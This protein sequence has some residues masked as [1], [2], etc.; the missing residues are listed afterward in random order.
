MNETGLKEN[1]LHQ[2]LIRKPLFMGV[3]WRF[4]ILEMG[5]VGAIFFAGGLRF[6]S[7]APA[8]IAIFLIHFPLRR[9]IAADPMMIELVQRCLWHHTYYAPTSRIFI[10]CPPPCPSIDTAHP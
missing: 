3:D 4:L 6:V 7:F 9:M 5:I 2:S 10:K 1:T 8:L